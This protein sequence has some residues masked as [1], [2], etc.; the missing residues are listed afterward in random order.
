MVLVPLLFLAID[1]KQGR[2]GVDYEQQVFVRRE[3]I[4]LFRT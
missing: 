4:R 2:H 1:T 3:S